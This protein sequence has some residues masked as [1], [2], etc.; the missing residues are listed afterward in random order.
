L[1]A[2]SPSRVERY[3]AWFGD[4]RD[5]VLYF[6]QAAFWSTAGAGGGD[7]RADLEH[8]GPQQVGRFDLAREAFL[9]PLPTGARSARSGTW[10]VLAHPNGRVYFTTFFERSGWIDPHQGMSKLFTGAGVGLN[11]LALGPDGQVLVTRYGRPGHTGS[12]VALDPEGRVLAEYPLA[13]P[14]EGVVVAAKS[15]SFDPVRREVWVNSDLVPVDAPETAEGHDARVLDLASGRERLRVEQ[16][17]LHFVR[18]EPDGRGHFAW[19]DGRRLVLRTTGPGEAEPDAGREVLLDADF[20]TEHDFV[21]DLTVADDG[22]VV[23]TRWSGV[24]HVVA[25]EASVRTVRLPALAED[26]LY[27]TAV[28]KGDRLCATYCGEVAVVCAPIP[29]A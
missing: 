20:P 7:P 24:V 18:F 23:A 27:Y 5:G 17:E 2:A 10:D 22:R 12:V 16:P 1:L 15:L 8:P 25:P 28:A 9:A 3:C 29:G 6:G 26:G 14:R 4:E 19:L 13:P 21:Q 11:E